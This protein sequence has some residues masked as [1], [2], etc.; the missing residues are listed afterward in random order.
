MM[1]RQLD[2]EHQSRLLEWLRQSFQS[3][4]APTEMIER[5]AA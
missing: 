3:G 4:N 2:K 5:L 1:R